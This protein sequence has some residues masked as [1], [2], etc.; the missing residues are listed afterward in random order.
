MIQLGALARLLL[1]ESAEESDAHPAASWLALLNAGTD[2]VSELRGRDPA[3]WGTGS[4]ELL[5]FAL[6]RELVLARLKR[7][8]PPP[9]SMVRVIRMR[10]SVA[11][12]SLVRHARASL[13]AGAAVLLHD[14][15]V[16]RSPLDDVIAAAGL[17][18]HGWR[19]RP[20][21]GGVLLLLGRR[22]GERVLL[23]VGSPSA[24]PAASAEGL[25]RLSG[26]PLVPRLLASSRDGNPV[27]TLEQV[28]EGRR[29]A[30]LGVTL[31]RDA[32]DFAAAMPPAAADSAPPIIED[33]ALVLPRH[34]AALRAV[35]GRAF[36]A[37]RDELPTVAVHGDFWTGNLLTAGRRLTGVVDWDAFRSSGPAGVDLLHLVAS[38]DR[39]RHGRGIGAEVL[40][41]PWTSEEF[42]SAAAPYWC[43][44]G[45][46]PTARVLDA[47][48]VVWWL[49]QVASTLVRT[50]SHAADDEWVVPNVTRV[51]GAVGV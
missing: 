26:S 31:R 40:L 2:S 38:E 48:G 49:Q 23:R 3:P 18:E 17:D 16:T 33:L 47:L 37:V 46:R 22:A 14:G 7:H 11:R 19:V 39:H 30:R 42:A 9:Y 28:L 8:P 50:P 12:P 25:R 44:M 1:D 34:A 20:R 29:P 41:K 4:S 36:A 51:L 43:A 35:G 15:S 21:S 5:R 32:V 10:P 6:E 24:L 45:V 13:A 27:W